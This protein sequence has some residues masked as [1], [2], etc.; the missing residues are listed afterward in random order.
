MQH[1][2]MLSRTE[3]VPKLPHR[4]EVLLISQHKKEKHVKRLQKFLQ[5][6]VNCDSL[7]NNRYTLG[8]LEVC[9]LSF[10]NELGGKEK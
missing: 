5:N 10:V 6:V 2:T 7:R 4:P 8:L 9:Y 1:P 3:K